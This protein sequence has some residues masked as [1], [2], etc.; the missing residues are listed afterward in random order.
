MPKVV[1]IDMKILIVTTEIGYNE[2]GRAFSCSQLVNLLSAKHT[3]QVNNPTEYFESTLNVTSFSHVEEGLRKEYKLKADCLL[4]RDVDIVIAFGANFNGYYAS[5]LAQRLHKPFILSLRG[6]DVNLA[7]WFYEKS[8]YLKETCYNADKILCLSN[9]MIENVALLSPSFADKTLIIPNAV[10]SECLPVSFPN[11]PERIKVGCAAS[12]M[13]EKKGIL[14]LLN[15]VAEFKKISDLPIIFEVVG[16]ID[17]Y[18]MEHYYAAIQQKNLCDSVKFIDYVTR[19]DLKTIMSSWDFYVQGSIC[20]GQ[21][22]SILECLQNGRAFISSA[23]GFWSELLSRDYSEIF[24][25]SWNPAVM[26]KNLKRLIELEHKENLYHAAYDKILKVCQK[27]LVS[28]N[29]EKLLSRYLLPEKNF[30]QCNAFEYITTLGLHDVQLNLRDSITMTT[31]AFKDFVSFVHKKGYSLC[32]MKNYIAGT[33][34]ERARKIVCTF[35]DGYKT[36]LNVAQIL[37]EYN[38]TATAFIC[39]SLLG[40]D[41]TWNNK[42]ATL[43]Q[44]LTLEELQELYKSGWEIGSHGVT[45]RNLS[46]LSLPEIENE[47][48]ESKNFLEKYFGEIISYAYPYG[49]Y[50]NFVLRSVKKY[51]RYSFA[52]MN[53]GNSLIADNL[54]IRRYSEREIYA[55]LNERR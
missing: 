13:N 41:N 51:Y 16:H 26:A 11:L 25:E 24:F 23:T 38:F 19:T 30:L 45:H 36:L 7:K 1:K 40:K 2:G 34:A 9:E 6:S 4:Y 43:R 42:D 37:N 31:K 52:V 50:N 20:E 15:M 55:M 8:W 46:K 47:L 17:D 48:S 10:S 49:D 35:D 29:W 3:V 54:K 22:N 39:T 53:G 21:P 5:I 27:N 14:N 44:H 12:Q 33:P 32:S 18:L 28:E